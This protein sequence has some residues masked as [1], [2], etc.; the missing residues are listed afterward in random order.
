VEQQDVPAVS[1]ETNQVVDNIFNKN[2]LQRKWIV[3][4]GSNKAKRHLVT[5]DSNCLLLLKLPV[6][7]TPVV[8]GQQFN[9]FHD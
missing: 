9:T 1:E 2:E 5:A 4:W 3:T 8:N 7:I 6:I